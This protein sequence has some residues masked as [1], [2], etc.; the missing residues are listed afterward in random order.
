MWSSGWH[1]HV[2]TDLGRCYRNLRP[3][4]ALNGAAPLGF[5]N[6][7]LYQLERG[8]PT[9]PPFHEVNSVQNGGDDLDQ[10]SGYPPTGLGTPDVYN[11]AGDLV[12]SSSLS[13]R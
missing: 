11:I 8:T 5:A 6:P 13:E 3:E 1:Q 12:R 2:G 7:K 9:S 10:S 4:A